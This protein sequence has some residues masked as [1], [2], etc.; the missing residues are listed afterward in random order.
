[1]QAAIALMHVYESVGAL[2]VTSFRSW[3][4]DVLIFSFFKLKP[5]A[6]ITCVQGRNIL[7]L[8]TLKKVKTF[9]L[10]TNNK[11]CKV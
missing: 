8:W 7:K 1:M 9:T 4:M 2:V 11:A 10:E 6:L 3:T 5:D